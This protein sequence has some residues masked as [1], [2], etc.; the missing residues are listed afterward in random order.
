MKID[1]AMTYRDIYQKESPRQKNDSEWTSLLKEKVNSMSGKERISVKKNN[2]VSRD[3]F[4]KSNS[5]QLS[6]CQLNEVQSSNYRIMP[7]SKEPYIDIFDNNGNKL[8]VFATVDI[9]IKIDLSTKTEILLSSHGTAAYDVIPMTAELKEDLCKVLDTDY[10]ESEEL[11]G[12]SIKTHSETGIQYVLRD[13][14]EGRGGRILIRNEVEQQRFDALAEKYMKKY[15]NLISDSN[16]A[17]IY[18]DL[19]IRGLA[20]S[21]ETGIVTMGWNGASYR[22]N[23]DVKKNWAMEF[24]EDVFKRIDEWIKNHREFMD[25]IDRISAWNDMFESLG[26]N[27]DRI[28]SDE[29][30]KQGYLYQQ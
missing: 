16:A 5:E 6:G 7:R 18:A 3:I 2:V 19:E 13:G 22:D 27:Y 26:S 21:T 24:T 23:N 12:Y 11:K 20:K 15:P 29:E 17:A 9:N 14:E 28:W 8:G 30:L 1:G 25:K 4:V 10:L